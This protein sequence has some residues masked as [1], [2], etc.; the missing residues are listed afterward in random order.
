MLARWAMYTEPSPEGSVLVLS[1]VGCGDGGQGA[2]Q[3]RI[4]LLRAL[5]GDLEGTG[6]F[7]GDPD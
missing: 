1:L 5:T 3:C 4:S 6:G 7:Q 2:V